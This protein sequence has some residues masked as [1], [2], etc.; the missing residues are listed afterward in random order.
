MERGK[1]F[2]GDAG[3][4]EFLRSYL[5]PRGRAAFYE[6]GRNIMLDEPH[7]E[8]GLWTRLATLRPPALFVWGDSDR[9]VPAGFSRHVAEAVPGA[10]QVILPECGHV[11]QVERPEETNA[12][13]QS[14]FARVEAVE[15]IPRRAFHAGAEAA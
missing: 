1:P 8:Q 9:L 4:D 12:L 14:F 3:V 5:T 11:P 15:P 13:L 6:A 10:R 2:V 7:G